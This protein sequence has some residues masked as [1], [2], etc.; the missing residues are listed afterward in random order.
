VV[1]ME[2]AKTKSASALGGFVSLTSDQ[3]LCPYTSLGALSPD[4]R[5]RLALPYSPWGRAL[6]P[7]IAHQNRHCWVL[8]TIQIFCGFWISLQ[9]SN[10]INFFLYLASGSTIFAFIDIVGVV[11]DDVDDSV[12]LFQL[13]WLLRPAVDCNERLSRRR[14]DRSQGLCQEHYFL[15]LCQT[16]NQS[17]RKRLLCCASNW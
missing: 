11:D 2:R 6:H 5:Y 9:D 12:G 4:P 17:E 14:T 8:E 1:L 15:L 13:R 10:S 3:G 16:I 7:D